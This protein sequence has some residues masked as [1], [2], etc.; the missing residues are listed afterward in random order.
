M[1]DPKINVHDCPECDDGTKGNYEGR[2][3][4]NGRG[5]FTC[6][7]CGTKWQDADEKPSSKGW[8]VR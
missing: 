7:A 6:P 1:A 2:V 5:V 4:I 3:L 8:R